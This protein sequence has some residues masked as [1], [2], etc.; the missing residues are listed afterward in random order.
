MSPEEVERNGFVIGVK[1]VSSKG[2]TGS[3]K[4]IERFPSNLDFII[5]F[6][7]DYELAFVSVNA[8]F[9]NLFNFPF[10]LS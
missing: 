10:F 3:F 2:S 8:I 4:D 5:A 7:I 6:P 1:P 9:E